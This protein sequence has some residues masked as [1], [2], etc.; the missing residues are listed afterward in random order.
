VRWEWIVLP[1]LVWVLGVGTLAG[2]IW[3]T[4]RA[5][6]PKWKN[7]PIPLMFLYQDGSEKRGVS[8]DKV[9]R[10][11]NLSMRLY[12]DDKNMVLANT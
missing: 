2:T 3:K 6:V 7:D 1:G 11:N 10:A 4:R 8:L 5:Q 12:E 9:H